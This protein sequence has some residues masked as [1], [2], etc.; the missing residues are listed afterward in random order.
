MN[1][2]YERTI[3]SIFRARLPDEVLIADSDVL[4]LMERRSKRRKETPNTFRHAG[5]SAIEFT[6]VA[7]HQS[8]QENRKKLFTSGMLFFEIQDRAKVEPKE[9]LETPAPQDEIIDMSF[10]G[11]KRDLKRIRHDLATM[12]KKLD[13][14]RKYIPDT[15]VGISHRDII[16]PASRLLGVSPVEVSGEGYTNR[17][18]LWR[19]MNY[20]DLS[21]EA[22]GRPP[23]EDRGLYQIAIPTDD[24]IERFS[25]D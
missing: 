11:D 6:A 13:E 2:R 15:M 12:A 1:Y 8:L 25:K 9:P 4:A 10:L 5:L 19:A 22:Y 24:F 16:G 3:R 17:L 18:R 7:I 14:N 23:L 20:A 21:R